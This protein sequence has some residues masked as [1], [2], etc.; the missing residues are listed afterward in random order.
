MSNSNSG[1]AGGAPPHQAAAADL[2]AR[3]VRSITVTL[4]PRSL[5]S[6]PS[7]LHPRAILGLRKEAPFSGGKVL[8]TSSWFFK[9]G[10][11]GDS[12]TSRT[13]P[14]GPNTRSTHCGSYHMV[15]IQTEVS[16]AWP[17]LSQLSGSLSIKVDLHQLQI[18]NMYFNHIKWLQVFLFFVL[19]F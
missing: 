10:R 18:T 3:L 2:L 15:M 17:P 8:G 12:F 14:G 13:E 5:L 6:V 4:L 7:D 19:F 11:S 1:W 16:P 9:R